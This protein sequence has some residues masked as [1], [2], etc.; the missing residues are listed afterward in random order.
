M[1][2]DFSNDYLDLDI[3]DLKKKSFSCKY[4]DRS[5]FD[6]DLY[7]CLTFKIKSGYYG[8]VSEIIDK[9]TKKS[10]YKVS[11]KDIIEKTFYMFIVVPKD[12][13]KV[14]VNKGIILFQ[15]IGAFGVKTITTDLIKDFFS[16]K[17]N[18]SIKCLTISPY[19]F[20]N[21]VLKKE[22]IKKLVMIKNHKSDDLTDKYFNGYGT[23]SRTIGNLNFDE[24]GWTKIFSKIN[25]FINSKFNLFEFENINY[26]IFKIIVS[27]NGKDRVINLNNI[28][29]LSIIEDIPNEIKGI[30]GEVILIDLIEHIKNVIEDYMKEMVL[31][32]K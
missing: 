1:F 18:I 4:L 9:E 30:D 28:E 21:K 15:N 16:E 22:N 29:N 20:V 12:N 11:N 26:D 17:Y 14:I 27:I 31:Q 2:K 32:I 7:R 3:N 25:N 6:T 19:L 23:E 10:K 13:K 5:S 8:S 24:H